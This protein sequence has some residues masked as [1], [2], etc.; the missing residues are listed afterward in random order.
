MSIN[1]GADAI[2]LAV[3]RTF[4]QLN[5]KLLP[6][7]AQALLQAPRRRRMLEVRDGY[8]IITDVADRNNRLFRRRESD[9]GM[10]KEELNF[11]SQA[12]EPRT[13]FDVWT[14]AWGNH[15]TR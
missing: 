15:S 13:R 14:N 11:P 10:T 8:V 2:A 7:E 1:A 4:A 9:L 3:G 6:Q 5:T 12:S